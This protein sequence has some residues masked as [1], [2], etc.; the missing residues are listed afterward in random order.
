[1]NAR[2]RL[3]KHQFRAQRRIA[4]RTRATEL[5]PTRLRSSITLQNSSQIIS[6]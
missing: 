6:L 5:D 2:A 3:L 1:M 4:Q